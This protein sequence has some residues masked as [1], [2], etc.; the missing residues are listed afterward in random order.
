M[1]SVLIC[2]LVIF[3]GF[4]LNVGADDHDHAHVEKSKG[5]Q[6]ACKAECPA[7][8]TEHQAHDCMKKLVKNNKSKKLSGTACFKALEAHEAEEKN[9]KHG[10]GKGHDGHK[11]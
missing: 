1:K 10:K 5:L 3:F 2:A 11:H 7:A 6:V 4:S 8:K 9:H